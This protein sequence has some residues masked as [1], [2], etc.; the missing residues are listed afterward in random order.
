LKQPG[1]GLLMINQDT[2]T[3]RTKY[4]PFFAGWQ[5]KGIFRI[6]AIHSKNVTE[7]HYKIQ[8]FSIHDDGFRYSTVSLLN[9]EKKISVIEDYSFTGTVVV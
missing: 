4:V 2:G 1:R 7:V 9:S 8:V 3:V 5:V 6:R